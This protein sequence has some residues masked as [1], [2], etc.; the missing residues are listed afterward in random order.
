MM[1]SA[2][3]TTPRVFGFPV[4]PSLSAN[5]AGAS[6]SSKAVTET[7]SSCAA[8]GN[9]W[10]LTRTLTSATRCSGPP[11]LITDAP[12]DSGPGADSG[13]HQRCSSRQESRIRQLVRIGNW[14]PQATVAI[15]LVGDAAQRVTLLHDALLDDVNRFTFL[16]RFLVATRAPLPKRAAQ[17]GS[18]RNAGRQEQ[19]EAL[20]QR[21]QDPQ[22]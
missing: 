4:F 7:R 14:S 18:H 15:F 19:R 11:L 6:R 20:R 9:G 22:I 2:P 21:R 12:L 16:Q 1:L 17:R 8:D 3:T 13:N 10:P 5:M